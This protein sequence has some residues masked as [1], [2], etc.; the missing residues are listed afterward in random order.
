MQRKA[1]SGGGWIR[2]DEGC[3]TVGAASLTRSREFRIGAGSCSTSIAS[4]VGVAAASA[5]SNGTTDG[6]FSGL[7]SR[8]CSNHVGRNGPARVAPGWYSGINQFR[9]HTGGDTAVLAI[10][11]SAQ[12]SQTPASSGTSSGTC[13][14]S[15]GWH[16]IDWIGKIRDSTREATDID[17]SRNFGATG[18]AKKQ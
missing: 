16:W 2:N 15:G 4:L 9:R 18:G 11:E 13:V 8:R 1:S 6:A 7:S 3:R 17:D 12:L 10:V 5:A 14:T